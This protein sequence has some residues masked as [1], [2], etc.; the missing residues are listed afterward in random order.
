MPYASPAFYLTYLALTQG[1]ENATS[2]FT[3]D[4]CSYFTADIV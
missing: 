3:L 1:V 2:K 4:M